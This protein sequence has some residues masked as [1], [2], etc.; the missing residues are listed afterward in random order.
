MR[1]RKA[2]LAGCFQIDAELERLR[3]LHGKI[4]GLRA[5]QNLVH[6]RSGAPEQVG[7]VSAVHNAAGSVY[8]VCG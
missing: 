5:F 2:D 8:S 7:S 1:N 4:G 6:L 3:L